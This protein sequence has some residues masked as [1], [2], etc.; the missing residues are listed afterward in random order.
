[1]ANRSNTNTRRYP[2][3]ARNYSQ[4]RSE[5]Y[6]DGSAARRLQ[7]YP[8]GAP[9]RQRPD[10]EGRPTPNRRKR[11]ATKTSTSRNRRVN[12]N[13]KRRTTAERQRAAANR[14]NRQLSKAAQRNRE[15]AMSLSRGF[16][17][18]IALICVAVLGVSV[19]YLQLKSELTVKKN[20]INVMETKLSE[21][22]ED[23]DAYY[24]QVTS[25]VDLTNIKK[26]AIGRL[27]MKNPSDEQ[28]VNYESAV[29]SYVRQ[30]QDVPETK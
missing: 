29:G 2:N 3:N 22:K 19:Y 18:F 6:V 21:L 11:P 24:S 5:M 28:T 4:T 8:I 26:I 7:E 10:L 17:V 12:T 14:Q 27:G 13:A 20:Q 25:N 16:V 9:N 15:K 23:N 30:Y 1:M